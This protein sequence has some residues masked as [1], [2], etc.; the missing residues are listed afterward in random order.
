MVSSCLL[1]EGLGGGVRVYRVQ[2]LGFEGLGFRP[3]QWWF[4]GVT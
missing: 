2:G 3:G 4:E 1:L